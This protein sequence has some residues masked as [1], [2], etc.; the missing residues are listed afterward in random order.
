MV[1]PHLKIALFQRNRFQN[2]LDS[3]LGFD[4]EQLQHSSANYDMTIDLFYILHSI[5]YS[6][7]FCFSL[8]LFIHGIVVLEFALFQTFN[9]LTFRRPNGRIKSSDR[10]LFLSSNH[11]FSFLLRLLLASFLPS[12]ISFFLSGFARTMGNNGP[13]I[14]AQLC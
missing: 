14:T 2:P 4:A 10:L 13:S 9:L 7:D 6:F 12:L 1:K 8:G 3:Q 11:M 5:G